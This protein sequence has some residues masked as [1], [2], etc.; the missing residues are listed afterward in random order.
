MLASKYLILI[1][2][3]SCCLSGVLAV[4]CEDD[5]TDPDCIDC[6]TDTTNSIDCT[7][8]TSTTTSTVAPTTTSTTVAPVAAATTKK[9]GNKKKVTLKNFQFKSK[10]TI[11][12]NR[13]G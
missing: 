7:T 8:T 11:K 12:V 5:P 13:S 1:A 9:A 3:I 6:S 10:R 4:T 2:A